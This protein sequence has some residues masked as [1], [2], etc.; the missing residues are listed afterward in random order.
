VPGTRGGPARRLL[1]V[2]L[3]LFAGTVAVDL[4]VLRNGFFLVDDRTVVTGN[5][6]VLDGL[7]AAGARWALTS[8]SY[9]SNWHPLTWLSHMADVEL[10][11]LDPRGHH[12]TS[13]LLHAANVALLFAVLAAL[14]GATWRPALAAALFAVHP[15]HVESL[16]WLAE[17]KDLLSA[18]FWLLA[19]A[20]HVAHARRPGARRY[21]ALVA[22]FALGLMS[23]PMVV[24]LPAVLL[25]LDW[26]PLGRLGF[27]GGPGAGAAARR[28][29]LEKVP[30]LALAAGASALTIVAQRA[31]GAVVALGDL[32]LGTRAAVAAAAIEHY[33]ATT[34]WPAGLSVFYPYP[35]GPPAAGRVA[36]ALLLLAGVTAAAVRWRETRPNLLAGWLAFLGMLVPVLGLVQVGAQAAADRFTYLPRIGLL[37]MLCWSL[38]GR[39]ASRAGRALAAAAGLAAVALL[40]PPARAQI[41]RWGDP[42]ALLEHGAARTPES[43]RGRLL[44]GEAYAAAGRLPEAAASYG[45][46]LELLPVLAPAEAGLGRVLLREGRPA[47]AEAHF[48]RAR[49]ADPRDATTAYG[50]GL[51]LAAQD[52]L[53][54]AIDAYRE[55]AA[56]DPGYL[57]A[58]GNLALALA[59]AGRREEARAAFAEALARFPRSAKLHV[60]AGRF[61]QAAGDAEGARRHFAEALRLDPAAAAALPSGTLPRSDE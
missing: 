54:E 31:G 52:R 37:L 53:A 13:L 21:L 56:L 16:A 1:P 11:G 34:L 7:T 38:P 55:A 32:P 40:V 36:A 58:R 29:L 23:K 2:A 5:P 6:H 51:A 10:H 43:W 12:L 3:L 27:P 19:V 41:E 9:A 61:L 33:L 60:N 48:R 20:A 45:R 49:L 15:L 26:W 24:T 14:T 22:A 35:Q 44:L 47:E 42:V 30:L 18:F 57:P 39:R 25:L 8:V 50:L 4:P 28:A 59:A 17:R 46:A